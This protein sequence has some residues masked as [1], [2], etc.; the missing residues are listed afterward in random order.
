MFN[1]GRFN[2]KQLFTAEVTGEEDSVNLEYLFKRDGEDDSIRYEI[3]G[4]YINTRSPHNPEVPVALIDG[5]YVY[6]PVHQLSDVKEILANPQ[7]IQAINDG[8]AAFTISSYV[9]KRYNRTCYKAV[10]CNAEEE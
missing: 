5:F 1:F 9:Q 2:K 6:L 8:K 3:H 10:W 4:L 7:A